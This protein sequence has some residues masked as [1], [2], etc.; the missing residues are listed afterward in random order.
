MSVHQIEP[1]TG[2]VVPASAI[3]H[4]WSPV[5]AIGLCALVAIA[6]QSLWIPLDADV[7]WLITVCERVLSG[8]RLYVDVIEVNPPASV[9]LYLPLVWLAHATGLKPEAVVAGGFVAAAIASSLCTVKLASRL[10][11]AP[12]PAFLAFTAGFVTLVFPM[13]LFAQR[14]HAALLLALPALTSLALIAEGKPLRLGSSLAS[15]FAA[16]LVI[17]IKPHFALAIVPPALWAAWRRRSLKPLLPGAAAATL[18]LALYAAAFLLKAQAFLE[19]LPVISHTYLRFHRPL[20][21]VLV[22]PIL[23]QALVVLPALILHRVRLP[24]FEIS[25]LLGALGFAAAAMAQAKDYPNHVLP[26]AALA[27]FSALTLLGAAE[28][29]REKWATSAA[30]ALVC[31]W[32][33]HGWEILPDPKVAEAITEVAPPHPKVI[34]LS[35]ELTTGHP[36]TRNIGGTWAGSRAG[37]YTAGLAYDQGLHDPI[38]VQAYHQDIHDFAADVAGNSPDVVLVDRKD[39]AWLMREPQIAQAMRGYSPRSR[40]GDIEVWVRGGR[41][42]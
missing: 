27:L 3:A 12:R 2:H 25:T 30:L 24:A 9:W 17:V 16:G 33:M 23:F 29:R 22:D 18:A 15:G 26:G 5:L 37:L 20:W 38:A 8:A 41:A 13:A 4:R 11:Q 6:I 31:L 28:P 40:A 19:W 21:N 39:K 34:A 32:Q 1:W 36:V 42:G 10:D 35:R 7:S 14:E